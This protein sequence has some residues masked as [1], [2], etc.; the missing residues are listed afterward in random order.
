[1]TRRTVERLRPNCSLSARSVG[2]G[3]RRAR[4]ASAGCRSMVVAQ[5]R[6]SI[7]RR[8]RDFRCSI[9]SRMVAFGRVQSPRRTRAHRHRDAPRAAPRVRP[10]FRR[11]QHASSCSTATAARGAL[12]LDRGPRRRRAVAD[13]GAA[14]CALRPGARCWHRCRSRAATSG[15]SA[16]TTTRTPRSCATSVFKDNA[17]AGRQLA[18]RL[19]Q[20]AR[21]GDRARH[22]DVPLPGAAVSTQI[23]YEAELAVV[24]GRGGRNITRAD[25]MG[26]S[27]ATPSSTT[28]PRA[29]CRCA[30]RQWDLG[31]SFD[32]FCPMGPWIVTADELD[33]TRHARALLGQRRAAPG[34]AHQPT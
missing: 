32:T 33:G 10:R 1:M 15:A 16:A 8:V 7:H 6:R 18:D 29:T 30:T 34:R 22:A 20:G 14:T 4:C 9:G 13:S 11:R 17:K 2:S 31:K 19:H 5:P 28:S 23:D 25:A 3:G 27:S 21:D 24:I 12:P 26:T